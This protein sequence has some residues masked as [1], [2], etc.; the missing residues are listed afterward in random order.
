MRTINFKD[1]TLPLCISHAKVRIIDAREAFA[2]LVYMNINGIAAHDLAF[3]I[4]RSD[5]PTAFSD[6]EVAIIRKVA[7]SCATP[8][9]LDG[10][11]GCLKVD[12]E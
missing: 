6:N 10:L 9:F 12:T 11:M 4:Y 2:D 3:K 7:E 5:G 8:A 1:F